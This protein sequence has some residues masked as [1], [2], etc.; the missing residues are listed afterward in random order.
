MDQLVE[1]WSTEADKVT[2]SKQ[3]AESV[4]LART[5]AAEQQRQ[6]TKEA[7]RRAVMG[8]AHREVEAEAERDRAIGMAEREQGRRARDPEPGSWRERMSQ[9]DHSTD[10][11]ATLE[12]QAAERTLDRDIDLGL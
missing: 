11:A 3:M 9:K 8:Q 2:A 5:T 7:L 12:R 6:P 1:L 10:L 4:K